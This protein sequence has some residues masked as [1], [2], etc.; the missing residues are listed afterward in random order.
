MEEIGKTWKE[1]KRKG[2]NGKLCKKMIGIERKWKDI[3]RK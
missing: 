2:K 3:E 1:I